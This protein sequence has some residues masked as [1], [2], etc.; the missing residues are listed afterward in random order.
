M[1]PR[2]PQ[3]QPPPRRLSDQLRRSSPVVLPRLLA[4]ATMLLLLLLLRGAEAATVAQ[5]GQ[6]CHRRSVV[7]GF[8]R[9]V[10]AR[11]SPS[12]PVA[13]HLAALLGA[14]PAASTS[15]STTSISSSH[16][17]RCVHSVLWSVCIHVLP[18]GFSCRISNLERIHIY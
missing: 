18:L 10:T 14:S 8:L 11:S 9:P 15:T 7:A 12:A 17:R 1:L 16:S 4:A 5:Q 2:P 13:R 3:L 6:R